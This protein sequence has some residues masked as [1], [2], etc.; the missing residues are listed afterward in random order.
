MTALYDRI[1]ASYA[2]T[3]GEEPRFATVIKR[4]SCQSSTS[5]IDS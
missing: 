2:A 1:G 5:V 3:R 4:R